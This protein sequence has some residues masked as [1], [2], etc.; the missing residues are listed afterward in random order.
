LDDYQILA[1]PGGF[2]HGDY[3]AA[4]KVLAQD[5]SQSLGEK[6]QKFIDEDKL[7]IGICNGFQ[8]LVKSGFL[9]R[10]DYKNEQTVTLT[11]NDSG[12][13]ED[14][15]VKLRSPENN[16][17]WT[18]GVESIDLPVAHGEG[19]FVADEEI[20][21]RLFEQN[22]VVF[23]YA[24][25]NGNPTMSYSE[26]PNGSMYSIAGICDETGRVFGLMPHPER[27]NNPNNHHLASLQKILKRDY[28]D[29]ANIVDRLKIVGELP[30]EGLGLKIFR[31]AVEYFE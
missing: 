10:L 24:D 11:Y 26:N 13:F 20:I 17:V 27:Y 25:Q 2:S 29:K 30:E 28:V 15:W 12:N 14:R 6:I 4:G 7:I 21:E 23:Q 31:N 9:P 22:L 18:K 1:L 8:V 5:L 16:C 3:I 19:K